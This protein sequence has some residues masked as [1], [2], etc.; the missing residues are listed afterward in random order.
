MSEKQ[1]TRSKPTRTFQWLAWVISFLL[2][3]SP[4]DHSAKIL[5]MLRWE[6]ASTGMACVISENKSLSVEP[7]FLLSFGGKRG[8]ESQEVLEKT[9]GMLVRAF[10]LLTL[11]RKGVGI[12]CHVD[13]IKWTLF[14]PTE[15]IVAKI[16]QKAI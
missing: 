16:V 10:R 1:K 9:L 4:E 6:I 15:T 14:T 8:S 2:K 5:F 3:S 7:Y 12:A 11:F 13:R